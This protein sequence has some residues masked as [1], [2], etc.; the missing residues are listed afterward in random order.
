[1]GRDVRREEERK[2]V[3][4]SDREGLP[5]T[6]SE[7]VDATGLLFPSVHPSTRSI[8][9]KRERKGSSAK[10]DWGNTADYGKLP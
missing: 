9:S 7:P 5:L 1:M 4:P 6:T 8:I 3:F 2:R 10:A